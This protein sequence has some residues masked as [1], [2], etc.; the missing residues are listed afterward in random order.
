MKQTIIVE[1]TPK[2]EA[3]IINWYRSLG[4][5][6]VNNQTV[7]TTSVHN[8]AN[9]NIV[10]DTTKKVKFTFERDTAHPNYEILNGY[11]N[12]CAPLLADKVKYEAII[13]QGGT[14]K[15]WGINV[16]IS[17]ILG[18]IIGVCIEASQVTSGF[19]GHSFNAFLASCY[20]IIAFVVIFIPSLIVMNIKTKKKYKPLIE[21]TVS[22]IESITS[23]SARY[24]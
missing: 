23:E 12:R 17:V 2:N 21:K 9:G 10:T 15:Q 18:I 7:V 13:S 14:G 8:D 3:Q 11:Y 22:E 19:F 1:D 20:S 16:L 4:W 6:L 24:A 5:E